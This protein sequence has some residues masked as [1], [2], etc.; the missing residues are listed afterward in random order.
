MAHFAEVVNKVYD[1]F[2]ARGTGDRVLPDPK[3]CRLLCMAMYAFNLIEAAR[4]QL[5]TRSV[6]GGEFSGL[7]KTGLK[8]YFVCPTVKPNARKDLLVTRKESTRKGHNARESCSALEGRWAQQQD[9]WLQ[10]GR[11]R[12]DWTPCRK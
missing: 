6:I 8:N 5:R 1:C 12:Q 3:T 2:W 7:W 4:S 10:P 9:S 11:N